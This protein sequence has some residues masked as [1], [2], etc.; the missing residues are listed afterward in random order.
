LHGHTVQGNLTKCYLSTI[1]LY[2]MTAGY[3]LLFSIYDLLL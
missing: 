3:K 1:Y 2:H